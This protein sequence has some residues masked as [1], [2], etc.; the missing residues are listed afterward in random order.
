MPY[1]SHC[2]DSDE[3]DLVDALDFGRFDEIARLA[4]LAASY[5][6]S[7]Q[8]AAERGDVL[9]ARVHCHQVRLVTREAFALV[10]ILGEPEV[11]E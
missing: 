1:A 7:I 3:P 11:C 2:G 10:K 6:H 8:L 4:T 9:T 5:W